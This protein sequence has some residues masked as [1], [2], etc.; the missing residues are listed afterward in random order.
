ME[1]PSEGPF[2]GQLKC[3]CKAG[4]GHCNHQV[5]LLYTLAHFLK[6]DF[7]SVP[8][9]VSKTSLPHT[10]GLTPKPI[11]TIKVSKL[12]CSSPPTK[13]SV[14]SW[15]SKEPCQYWKQL[16]NVSSTASIKQTSIGQGCNRVWRPALWISVDLPGPRPAHRHYPWPLPTVSSAT[17]DI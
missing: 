16:S 7:K 1:F 13:W 9:T 3:N 10:L 15:P 12:P 4:Q 17:T 6:V 8:P 14:C 5:G 11:N 2:I